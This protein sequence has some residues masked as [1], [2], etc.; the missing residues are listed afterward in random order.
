MRFNITENVCKSYPQ[1]NHENLVEKNKI[2]FI[3][4]E[5]EWMQRSI[6]PLFRQIFP[7]LDSHGVIIPQG[8]A[9]VGNNDVVSVRLK[10]KRKDKPT[11]G[12]GFKLILL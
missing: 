12:L 7:L 11:P 5:K 1:K 8:N 9:I 6:D 3:D 4:Q 10:F 2:H